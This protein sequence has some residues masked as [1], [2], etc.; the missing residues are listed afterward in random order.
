M[1]DLWNSACRNLQVPI[2]LGPLGA[3]MKRLNNGCVAAGMPCIS[4]W[5]ATQQTLAPDSPPLRTFHLSCRRRV[6]LTRE[7]M[8]GWGLLGLCSE[9]QD[10]G[11]CDLD[12]RGQGVITR[13]YWS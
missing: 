3:E 4:E 5:L 7:Q 8:G 6:K 10:R 2:Q 13:L 9:M 11:L 12:R 1:A